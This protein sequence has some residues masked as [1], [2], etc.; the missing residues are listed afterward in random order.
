MDDRAILT[1]RDFLLHA[2]ASGFALA[3]QPVV[4]QQVIT[5]PATGLKVGDA[6]VR[7]ADGKTLPVYFA[8]PDN[9]E[10]SA[11]VL[12]VQ[13]IFGVHEHIRDVCRRFARAGYL[14]IAP[15]L[16]F[17][18]GDPSSLASVQDIL[19]RIVSRVPDAQVMSD[20]DACV[21]WADGQGGDAKRVHVT[22]FC[23][24]GRVTWL[25][26]AHRAGL[27]SGVAWYGRLDGVP[28]DVTPEHP[29]DIVASIKAPVLGLYGGKD[30]GI[31]VSD[32]DAMR[33]AL[34]QG[35]A[36][37]AARASEIVLY[38][39]APHAFHADYRPSYRA[40]EAQDGW[41]RCLD[42]MQRHDG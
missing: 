35:T 14:A 37:A 27:R 28:N 42:W 8:R 9:G 29:L 4:A 20:L 34:A 3:V 5:T 24:G 33:A 6:S 10:R 22:G 2:G 13:E 12:V 26:A 1:R 25:Y 23:W 39:D 17:R 41:K 18:Q 38:P 31:P 15:E 40:A 11:V 30:Q 21:A 36:P 16:Y 7:A 32:V 19:E